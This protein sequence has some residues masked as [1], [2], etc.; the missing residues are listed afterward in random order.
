MARLRRAARLA[1]ALLLFANLG[2][3]R[4]THLALPDDAAEAQDLAF[5]REELVVRRSVLVVLFHA[6]TC[7]LCTSYLPQFRDAARRATATNGTRFVTVNTNAHKKLA[8]TFA[9]RNVPYTAILTPESWYRVQRGETIINAPPPV[10]YN[11][12]LA[13]APTLE[14]INT[15]LAGDPRWTPVPV[16]PFIT[17]LETPSD[18][19][20]KCATPT[21]VTCLVLFYAPWCHHCEDFLR[22][23]VDVGAHFA[24]VPD[25]L[26]ARFDADKAEHR[27]HVAAAGYNVTGFPTLQLFPKAF[28][29]HPNRRPIVFKGERSPARLIAFAETPSS[30]EAEA[31]ALRWVHEDPEAAAMR[32]MLDDELSD[33]NVANRIFNE[34]HNLAGNQDW[35]ASLRLLLLLKE[36][37]S[38]RKTGTASSKHMWNLLDNVKH[39]IEIGGKHDALDDGGGDFAEGAEEENALPPPPDDGED[40]DDDPPETVRWTTFDARYTL[41]GD[42]WYPSGFA[43]TRR[44][45]TPW[46]TRAAPRADDM[47]DVE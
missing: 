27:A 37:P 38:L 26:V 29:M 40:V 5:V 25:V 3:A 2:R 42:D 22:Y 39:N 14:W 4:A 8:A 45:L 13:A 21:N 28:A 1:A 10:R 41:T 47:C 33:E 15:E 24:D 19:E 30:Y 34:A 35:H 6:P 43:I 36:T 16:R 32:E 18:L 7:A 9:I 20:T 11:G 46:W 44:D 23:Y 17:S 12:Y 31:E